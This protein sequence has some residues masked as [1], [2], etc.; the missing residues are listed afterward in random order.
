MIADLTY[1][2]NMTDDDPKLIREMIEIFTRQVDEYSFEFQSLYNKKK[3]TDLSRLA[4][5]VKSSLAIMGMNDLSDKMKEL[6]VLAEKEK[7][8]NRYQAIIQQFIIESKKAVKE[9]NHIEL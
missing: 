4:H 3:W 8:I 6:E 2:K 5:K 9:L 7:D 1:L